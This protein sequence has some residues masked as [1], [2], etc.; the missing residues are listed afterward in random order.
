[1][2]SF[3]ANKHVRSMVRLALGVVGGALVANGVASPEVADAFVASTTEIV[4][5]LVPIVGAAVWSYYEKKQA[6]PVGD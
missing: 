6:P 4:V 3:L 5:G 1:M 2:F